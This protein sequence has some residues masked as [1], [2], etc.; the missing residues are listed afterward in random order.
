MIAWLEGRPD[1]PRAAIGALRAR[2]DVTLGAERL[3]VE[4]LR[5]EFDRKTIE[6]RLAYVFAADQ[7]PARVDA[8]LNAAEIDLD[9]A[10][11]FANNALA[12]TTFERPGEIA[13]ALDFGRATY[14]GIEAKG[15][16]AK[17]NFDAS[18]L[19]IERLAVAD[20]GGAVVNAN[21][22]IDTTS[23]S[24]PRGSIALALE[25][26]RLT[27]VAALAAR[28]APGAADMLQAMTRRAASAKLAAKLDVGPASADADAKTS[29]KLTVDGAIAGVRVKF[30]V[31]GSGV[32]VSPATADI[33]LDGR[34]DA[35][36]GAG[37]AA[38]VGL[39]RFA[40]V[41]QRPAHVTVTATGPAGGDLRV[42]GKFNGA[43]LDAAARGTLHFAE[44]RGAFDLTFTAADAR[45][46]RRDPAAAVPVTFATRLSVD[47]ERLTL[48]ALD[49]KIAGAAVKGQ[50]GLVLGH[51]TRIEGRI[52]ADTIDAAAV[53]ATAIGTPVSARRTGPWSPEP[54]APGPLADVDG[55]VDFTVARRI[56]GRHCGTAA[57]RD[58]CGSSRRPSFWT[59][60]KAVWATD[61]CWRGPSS[62]RLRR[63]CRR[64]RRSR[65]STRICRPCCRARRT[66]ERRDAFRCNST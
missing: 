32:T 8:A 15:A 54:F 5:A 31:E 4:G 61:V 18:G 39:D 34:L 27:G 66:G 60:S 6:G 2:G 23:Q 20:F 52:D 58:D 22:R 55:Q 57:A 46:P 17:L 35:D 12:G 14:A 26:Q 37:L 56:H 21:G 62:A 38:L 13:L 41:D 16:T 45:L 33:R 51:P 42:D 47:G 25:A 3:A 9:G 50:I 36:D 65:S 30:L 44:T 1:A 7:R 59:R 43:G 11:A 49:G 48:D 19:V 10:I 24:S 64:R 63:A 53:I 29:A 28:F 40:V